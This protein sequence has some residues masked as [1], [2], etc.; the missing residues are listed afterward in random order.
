MNSKVIQIFVSVGDSEQAENIATALLEKRLVACAQFL[1]PM[2]S[3]YRWQGK[4][5]SG[6]EHL[7]ILKT[8]KHHF[9]AVENVI[10]Q[11]HSYDVPE[12]VALD[13]IDGADDYL[14]WIKDETI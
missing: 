5:R 6:I 14:T 1:P 3:F 4:I 2:Q 10:K 9:S 11:L 12:I 7:L 13:I 8:Q